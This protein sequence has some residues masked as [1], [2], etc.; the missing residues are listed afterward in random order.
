MNDKDY[1]ECPYCNAVIPFSKDTVMND[2][3]R[4]N[5]TR[6]HYNDVNPESEIKITIYKCPRC[7][8]YTIKAIGVGNETA[9]INTVILPTSMAKQFP[10]Y[11]PQAIRTDYEEA[12]AIKNLSPKASATL[13]RRCLQG[14]IRDFWE[15]TETNLAKSIEKLE[16]KVSSTQW[17]VI[18]TVRK[19]GNIGAHME[20]DI[21]LIVD[22]EPDEATQLLTLIE[23]LLKQWYIERHDQEELYNSIL[24][25]GAEKEAERKKG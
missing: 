8:K 2:Y 22:I 17:K 4:F 14:M 16:G 10:D 21:N 18:D 23:L 3:V 19:I 13:S 20:K 5:P 6:D 9:S 7:K 24:S 25:M 12:F 11:I 15:I 1:I